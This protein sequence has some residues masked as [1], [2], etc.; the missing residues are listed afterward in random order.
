MVPPRQNCNIGSK[1]PQPRVVR[2]DRVAGSNDG[3]KFSDINGKY[4][5]MYCIYFAYE[6]EGEYFDEKYH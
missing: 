3:R 5:G 2:L 1:N 4:N 6:D